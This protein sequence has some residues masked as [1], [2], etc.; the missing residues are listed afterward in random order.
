MEQRMGPV[1]EA[2]ETGPAGWRRR[3]AEWLTAAGLAGTVL[4]A[5]LDVAER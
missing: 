2:Y 1:R 3:W 5:G 4:T